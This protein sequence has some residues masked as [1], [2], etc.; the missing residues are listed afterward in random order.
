MKKRILFTLMFGLLLFNIN[1]QLEC[2]ETVHIE[3]D[4]D[5]VG[6]V[7]ASDLVENI[8][9]ALTL[10]T[11]YYYINENTNGVFTSAADV[12][13]LNCGISSAYFYLIEITTGVELLD[14][15]NGSIT[16]SDPIGNCG[17][18][19]YC[20]SQDVDCNTTVSYLVGVDDTDIVIDAV[21]FSLCG[22]L[23]EC[24]GT[25]TV[26]YGVV[27]N[28]GTLNFTESISTFDA[29]SQNN[30]VVLAYA[31]NGG[32]T[33]NQTT[34]TVIDLGDCLLSNSVKPNI[35]LESAGT[36]NV[37]ADKLLNEEVQCDDIVFSLT[38]LG[39]TDP[40][41]YVTD[42]DID[43]DW[44][45]QKRVFLKNLSTGFTT[46]QP[47]FIL[48]PLE[49]CDDVLN[50][51]DRLIGFSNAP[52]SGTAFG[53]DAIINGIILAK[54]PGGNG[55]IINDS[56]LVAGE[57]TVRFVSS[58]FT[59]NGV[60]TIDLIL[61]Q[62]IILKDEW[63]NPIES[64]VFDIDQSG[65]NGIGDLITT[66]SYILG[67][68]IPA[69]QPEAY[70]INSDYVFPSDFDPFDFENTF[71]EYKFQMEDFETTNFLFDVY[72]V[73]DVNN[74]AIPEFQDTKDDSSIRSISSFEVSDMMVTSGEDFTFSLQY[75]S[76][77][78][79]KALLVALVSDGIEFKSMTSN[80]IGTE[81]N[82]LNK[83]EIRISY[84]SNSSL[85]ELTNISFEITATSDN[86]GQLIEL[87]GLK[88]GFPQEVV[89]ENNNLIVIDDLIEISLLSFDD[90]NGLE[91]N[92]YP[93]PVRDIIVIQH[94]ED[95]I[96]D[97]SIYDRMGRVV[98]NLMPSDIS[99]T[100][101]IAHYPKGLYYMNIVTSKGTKNIP[102][103]KE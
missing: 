90:I 48:D 58:A 92:L 75:S 62:R 38:D 49:A 14:Y 45:G 67:H 99:N 39:A 85:A 96:N 61:G 4:A 91:I 28:A 77:E 12:I 30:A 36:L 43:C 25:Y 32:T 7:L 27:A 3:L 9:F 6:Q 59:L 35:K 34:L 53:T 26:A 2:A 82:I 87:L 101:N 56:H 52:P 78:K 71:T 98:E 93:N 63:D 51:G 13:E 44:I 66:R 47:I 20:G 70:F 83:N 10:G 94:Q 102:F 37:T 21:S 19:Q 55:W 68:T 97:I 5:G 100:I 54:H 103:V 74:T 11:V 23:S 80:N 16:I 50:P 29:Q 79:F 1:A 33:Y 24:E 69:D 64:I 18:I 95:N 81:Y 22:T 86:N 40:G 88:N 65:Y 60:S 76:E 89:D 72:K 41:D 73:G 42:F 46:N 57:N 31:V 8:E 17:L 15:C 84:L